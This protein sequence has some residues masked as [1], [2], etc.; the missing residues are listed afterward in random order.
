MII[1]F[2]NSPGNTGVVS[3][4]SVVMHA[5]FATFTGGFDSCEC[6]CMHVC[7]G[8]HIPWWCVCGL[9]FACNTSSLHIPVNRLHFWMG[10]APLP[11]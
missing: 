4:I 7:I 9:A 11:D 1:D 10:Y 2:Y 5:A 3:A 6:A 8:L